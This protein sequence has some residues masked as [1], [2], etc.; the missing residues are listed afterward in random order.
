[1]GGPHGIVYVHMRG[2]G[3]EDHSTCEEW[4]GDGRTTIHVR[5]GE[6]MVGP[7]YM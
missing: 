3:R 5:G 7:Q 2:R 6:G 4:G 1:M